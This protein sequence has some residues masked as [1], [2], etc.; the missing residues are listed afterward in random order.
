M[1]IKNIAIENFRSY[2]GTNSMD[3]GEG[4]TLII[5]ANG[6]GKTTL[7]EALEWLFDTVDNKPKVDA[8]YI[9]KKK[10]AEM[11]PGDSAMVKVSMT[12][13]CERSEKIVE[14]S[15]KFTKSPDNTVSTSNYLHCIYVQNGSEKEVR[16]GDAA[17]RLFDIDFSASIRKYCLFKGEQELNIFNKEEAMSYL[18]E[19]FSKIRDFDPYIDFTGKAQKW[20]QDAH[21]NAIKADKK[22]SKD[23][24]RLRGLIKNETDFIRDKSE[25]LRNSQ[26]EAV[27]FT[28]LIN[29]VEQNKESSELLKATNTRIENLKER[30]DKAYRNISENYTFRLLDEM[31]ILMGFESIAREYGDYVATLDKEQ[32]RMEREFQREQGAKK[33]AGK[34]QEEI[35]QGFVPLALN[36][37]DENTMREMLHDEVCKVCGTPAP[38]GSKPY[39]TMKKHLEDYLA[40]LKNTHDEDEDEE[41]TL[42]KREFI[43][44]LVNRYTVLHNGMGWLSRLP[45]IIKAE[46]EK[47]RSNHEIADGLQAKLEQEEEQ[48]RKILAQTDGLT[49]EQLISVFN[50][51]SDWYKQKNQAENRSDF[52]KRQIDEHQKKKDE[53]QEEYSKISEESTAAMY[54][55]TSNAMRRISEAFLSAKVR[56]KREFLSQLEDTTNKYLERLNRGDFRGQAHIVEKADESAELMLIDT[57]G[58]R[59]Y[60]PNTALKTTMYMSLLFAVAELTTVKHEDDYPLI[61][62]APTSSFTAA[63]ESDFFGVIGEINKQ[64]II[65]TKSFLNENADGSSSIDTK[66]LKAIKGKKYRIEKKRPFDEKNLATIE[67]RIEPIN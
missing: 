15:F 11:M 48:K 24:E 63:K 35:N 43:R 59:I 20:A 29:T 17:K 67:T 65:V 55:R 23:A 16:E 52:L 51:I 22:N 42:F 9:S 60:N 28:T 4:L 57:D 6:D 53:Y 46:I 33:L 18:V 50:E 45:N 56:N 14:K 62:D 30:I 61:F 5:G 3:V 64:T 34:M 12:Y 44:E 40:S 27:N 21:D 36:I 49:E 66:R 31:W 13:E 25:E 47:N 10:I 41:E 37:P 54:G 8:K 1:I 58:A 38:K 39:N 19:T 7:F 32:R 26:K 2:Y